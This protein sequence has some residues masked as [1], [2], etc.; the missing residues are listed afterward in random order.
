MKN[1]ML[2]RKRKDI[3]VITF[4]SFLWKPSN[5]FLEDISYSVV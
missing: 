4:E 5:G 3:P 1:I 2:I